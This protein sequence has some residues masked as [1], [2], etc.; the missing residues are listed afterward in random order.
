MPLLVGAVVS[1]AVLLLYRTLSRYSLDQIVSSVRAVPFNRLASAGALAA[2]SY[3]WLTGFDWLALRY[4]G[5]PLPYWKAALASF[6]SL[7]LGHNI[8]FAGLS[9][10]AVRYRF[11]SRWGLSAGETA[12]LVLFCGV[13]VGLGL[14]GLGGVALLLRSDLAAEMTGFERSFAIALGALCLTLTASYVALAALDLPPLRIGTFSLRTPTL[15]IATAQLLIAMTNFACVAACLIDAHDLLVVGGIDRVCCIELDMNTRMP[16]PVCSEQ[17]RCCCAWSV[18]DCHAPN[19]NSDFKL[20]PRLDQRSKERPQRR[21]GLHIDIGT[22]PDSPIEVP[23]D[24]QDRSPRPPE[25][26]FQMTKIRPGIGQHRSSMRWEYP[27]AVASW[28]ENTPSGG[29][30]WRSLDSDAGF[31]AAIIPLDC[32]GPLCGDCL[33]RFPVAVR[34]GYACY[35]AVRGSSYLAQ[36]HLVIFGSLLKSRLKETTKLVLGFPLAPQ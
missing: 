2:A 11:Y 29:R 8:G 18:D 35:P 20:R 1:L 15:R 19:Q 9:S 5:K 23:A 17:Q 28:A 21:R 14:V 24:N 32:R 27:P 10:G 36:D 6:T 25:H 31:H 4:V 12:N 22:K 30:P 7:S 26:L 34:F 33:H 16:L 3:L 13:T